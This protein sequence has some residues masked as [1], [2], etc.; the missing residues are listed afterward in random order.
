MPF[1]TSFCTYAWIQ[2]STFNSGMMSI[3]HFPSIMS[4]I[5]SK[6][7]A[8]RAMQCPHFQ[9]MS[10]PRIPMDR[11]GHQAICTLSMEDRWLVRGAASPSSEMPLKRSE[12]RELRRR[13]ASATRR[14]S[15]SPTM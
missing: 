2:L 3:L 10:S 15:R 13:E 5:S 11:H 8:Q 6:K 4:I 1:K 7:L 14:S 9:S 12:G